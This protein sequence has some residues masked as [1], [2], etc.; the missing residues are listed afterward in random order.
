MK[1]KNYSASAVI[2]TN[3]VLSLLLGT[4][5]LH[6]MLRVMVKSVQ[7]RTITPTYLPPLGGRPLSYPPLLLQPSSQLLTHLTAQFQRL[8][9]DP[10]LLTFYQPCLTLLSML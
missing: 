1:N 4:A 5:N 9:G 3:L 7:Q 10:P 8:G 2:S 6:P